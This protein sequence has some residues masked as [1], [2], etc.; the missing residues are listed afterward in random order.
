MYVITYIMNERLHN[1]GLVGGVKVAPRRDGTWCIRIA[2]QSAKFDDDRE[3][4]AV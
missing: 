2:V 3:R 4:P 1:I